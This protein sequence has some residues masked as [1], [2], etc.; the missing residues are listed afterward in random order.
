M[1][2]SLKSADFGSSYGGSPPV[3]ARIPG[4][5]LPPPTQM[6]NISTNVRSMDAVVNIFV[7]KPPLSERA[8]K[9]ARTTGTKIKL[10][11]LMILD[12]GLDA[13]RFSAHHLDRAANAV[14]SKR[15]RT[16]ARDLTLAGVRSAAQHG[17][18][19]SRA[20]MR[21][22]K[23]AY[24]LVRAAVDEGFDLAMSDGDDVRSAPSK[25][26]A[27]L[28]VDTALRARA[29]LTTPPV[30][31]LREGTEVTVYPQHDAPI[32]WV[33]AQGPDGEIGFLQLGDLEAQT[34]VG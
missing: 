29:T 34:I 14:T 25:A 30:V 11:A 27:I 1:I 20:S 15:A 4:L 2:G 13:I 18:S 32:G 6:I 7:E 21:A 12:Y 31:E 23:R 8:E 33:L 10:T 22:L 24:L 9:V 3:E 19:G 28:C 16:K 17:A 26:D 5:G